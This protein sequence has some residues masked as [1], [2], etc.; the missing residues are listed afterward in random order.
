MKIVIE[1]GSSKSDWAFEYQ[2]STLFASSSGI[3]PT[4]Q[5]A[6]KIDFEGNF[7]NHLIQKAK[8]I[9]FY[10]A[11]TKSF[12]SQQLIIK[13]LREYGATGTIEVYSDLLGAA[14]ASCMSKQG[15]VC[16]LGTGSNICYY[17]GINIHQKTPA[18]G[19]ILGDEGS[20]FQIGKTILQSYFYQQM[21]ENIYQT[22]E[23][24]Y[25]LTLE[26][27]LQNV[28]KKSGNNTFIASFASFLEDCPQNWK[29]EILSPIFHS[30]VKQKMLIYPNIKQ[31]PV[32]FVGSIA[33]HFQRE[34]SDILSQYDVQ[35]KSILHKPLENLLSYHQRE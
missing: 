29:N 31:A 10:G 25:S 32:H 35:I 8:Q 12:E 7:P 26:M 15:I 18:L 23:K 27:V 17:D 9:Y 1:S 2:G 14:R 13:I 19:Y 20:G 11:G 3:N 21:P 5:I 16:I 33:F 6:Q 22:F 30:F 4:S 28:Y 34:L 24:K